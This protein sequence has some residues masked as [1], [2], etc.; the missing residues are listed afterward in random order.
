MYLCETNNE[1][2]QS[3]MTT[4]KTKQANHYNLLKSNGELS[5]LEIIASNK[6]DAIAIFKKKYPHQFYFGKIVRVYNDG[7]FERKPNR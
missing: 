5:D 7:F 4:I 1:I 3:K 2:K 6:K